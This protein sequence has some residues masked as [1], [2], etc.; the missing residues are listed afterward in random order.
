M[1]DTFTFEGQQYRIVP[2]PS[3]HNQSGDY[4]KACA[5]VR[6]KGCLF[7]S[8][9]SCGFSCMSSPQLPHGSYFVHAYVDVQDT[10]RKLRRWLETDDE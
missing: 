7:S 4:C 1:N 6:K 9:G 5:F 8:E 2:I 3:D 10:V